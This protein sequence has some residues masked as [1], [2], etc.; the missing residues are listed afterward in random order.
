MSKPILAAVYGSLRRGLGNH[1]LLKSNKLVGVQ[2]LD[3][4]TLWDYAPGSFPAITE[5]GDS[6]I[7]VELYEVDAAGLKRLDGLEGYPSFYN[8]K[9]VSTERGDA[10]I[11]FI[12][13]D[14]SHLN[15]VEDGDWYMYLV[16]EYK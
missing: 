15:K 3:G 7:T 8:R 1:R 13:E 10:W 14:L 12:E 5:G 16:N 4:F 11:Y 6:K 9:V 2:E